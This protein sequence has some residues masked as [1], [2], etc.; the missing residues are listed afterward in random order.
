M[1]VKRIAIVALALFAS[2]SCR[3]PVETALTVRFTEVRRPGCSGCSGPEQFSRI[4]SIAVDSEG[5]VYV[6]DLY[7]PFLR[8][9]R[10]DGSVAAFV[11]REGQGPGELQFVA[12]IFAGP[13]DGF[14]AVDLRLHRWIFFD[15]A[16][17]YLR[18]VAL[19]GAF[20]ASAYGD[21][22]ESLYVALRTVVEGTRVSEIRRWGLASDA[23]GA[24]VATLSDAPLGRYS[25]TPAA[26]YNLA[27]L[28]GGGFGIAYGAEEYLLEAFDAEGSVRYR[29]TRDVVRVP[30][31]EAEL[32]AERKRVGRVG[33]SLA[34]DVDPLRAHFMGGSLRY[35]DAGRAW[36][37][38]ERGMGDETIFDVFSS[39]GEY[40]GEVR[41]P[42]R[43]KSPGQGFD[44]AGDYM[45][46]IHAEETSG[47]EF[48][49]LW[50]ISIDE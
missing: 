10:A 27:A 18:T 7:A 36:I 8:V 33:G 26:L 22:D 24:V 13:G 2:V 35:D 3:E 30:R 19:P 40:L 39:T 9:W 21:S 44:L 50:R 5:G 16:G 23:D 1:F 42:L 48:V 49:T 14:S 43:I 6:A 11:G 41:L 12:E 34:A 25:G 15:A 38:T 20:T 4:R 29:T 28:P 47:V 45:V 37:S 31:T 17:R 32:E 46:T